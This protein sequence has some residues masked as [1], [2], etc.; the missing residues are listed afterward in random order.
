MEKVTEKINNAKNPQEL[1]LPHDDFELPFNDSFAVSGGK[2][3]SL[4]IGPIKKAERA[5]KKAKEYEEEM[6]KGEK[7]KIPSPSDYVIDFL[8]CTI[9]VEDPYLVAVIYSVL[10]KEE[11]ATCLQICRVKNKFVNK[12]LPKHIRT[13]VLINLAL[14]Y[15]HN[16]DEFK[17]SGLMGEFDSLMAGKCLMVCELQITMKDFLLIKRLSHSYYDITRVKPED[18]PNF[19]LS[20]GVFI[21]PNLDEKI[22]SVVSEMAEKKDSTHE[23]TASLVLPDDCNMTVEELLKCLGKQGYEIVKSKT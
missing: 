11:I 6:K 5:L 17:A 16:E 21:E 23:Q 3:A 1:G 8:R 19:L 10:L 4:S 20:N 2:R 9:E 14:L 18:L 15:P 12:K 22:P 13:N 7:E